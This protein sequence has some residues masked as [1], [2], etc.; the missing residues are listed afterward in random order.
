LQIVEVLVDEVLMEV[1][2]VWWRILLFLRAV[3]GGDDICLRYFVRCYCS[4]Q[5]LPTFE[6][7][8]IWLF[9]V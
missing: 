3:R 7:I 1:L 8:A 2:I 4:G 9:G 5:Y 6:S